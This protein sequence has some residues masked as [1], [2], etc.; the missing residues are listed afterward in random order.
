M[1]HS[2]SRQGNSDPIKEREEERQV[3]AR[4]RKQREEGCGAKTEIQEPNSQTIQIT[5]H[6]NTECVRH[7]VVFTASLPVDTCIG[8]KT[9]LSLYCSPNN[10]RRELIDSDD[11]L[12]L[13]EESAWEFM[14]PNDKAYVFLSEGV[15]RPVNLDNFSGF[16]VR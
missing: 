2:E 9:E 5:G 4:G 3:I 7:A 11:G 6:Y 1:P 15:V 14:Q 10:K 12:L 13:K 8:S 16:F